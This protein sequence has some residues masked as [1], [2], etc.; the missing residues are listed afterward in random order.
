MTVQ[1]INWQWVSMIYR[2]TIA[3]WQ[4]NSKFFRMACICDTPLSANL[5]DPSGIGPQNAA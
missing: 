5:F 4:K 2:A 1:V 3:L